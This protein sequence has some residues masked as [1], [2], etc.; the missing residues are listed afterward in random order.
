[1]NGYVIDLDFAKEY[2]EDLHNKAEELRKW[3]VEQLTPYH[4]GNGEINLNSPAQMKPAVSKA[5]GRE[6]PNM[7]AKKTLKPL[8]KEYELIEKLLE[9]RWAVKLSGT[10]IDALP[11]KQNPT[12]KRWHSRFN[13]MG[14]VT[15]RFSSGK[16]EEDTTGQGFNVQNQPDEARNMFVA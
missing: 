1:A 5:I 4:E 13:P 12:T 7:D 2:G 3:L 11:T 14:T 10:Y 6:L 8:A 16:D 9:Y 15:G